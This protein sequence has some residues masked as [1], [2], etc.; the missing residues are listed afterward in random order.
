MDIVCPAGSIIEA[1]GFGCIV[2]IFPQKGLKK[3]TYTNLGVGATQENTVDLLINGFEYEEAGFL[4]KNDETG[5]TKTVNLGLLVE[6]L[7]DDKGAAATGGLHLDRL[8][9]FGIP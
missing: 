3:V 7:L 5:V 6:Q 9:G 1:T 2:K 8:A 4:C